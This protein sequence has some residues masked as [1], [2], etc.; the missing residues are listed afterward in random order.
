MRTSLLVLVGLLALP[1]RAAPPRIDDADREIAQRHFR[2]ALARYERL[3]SPQAE[4][5]RAMLRTL[6][7]AP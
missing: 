6:G 7:C 4:E 3:G 2:E 1:A 5:P